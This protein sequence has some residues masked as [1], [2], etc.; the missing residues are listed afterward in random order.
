MSERKIFRI[1]IRIIGL[2]GILRVVNHWAHI[3]HVTGGI[4]FD[5]PWKLIF[6]ICLVLIGVYMVTGA[7][8]I[9]NFIVSKESEEKD[10]KE[11]K[12]DKN[13]PHP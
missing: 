11:E 13:A 7:P 8:L 2:L 5:D 12:T 4:H 3:Y 6:E 1:A 10:D 9:L